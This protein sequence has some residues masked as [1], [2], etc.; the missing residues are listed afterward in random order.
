MPERIQLRRSKGWRK[1]E[2]AVIVARPSRWGN[3]FVVELYG[4]PVECVKAYRDHLHAAALGDNLRS[5]AAFHHI[6]ANL[7]MLRGH[8]LACWCPLNEPCHADVLLEVA[9]DCQTR[10]RS[11]PPWCAHEQVWEV[12]VYS[13]GLSM[14]QTLCVC[15]PCM[16]DLRSRHFQIRAEG[17]IGDGQS[18]TSLSGDA[19]QPAPDAIGAEM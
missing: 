2:G 11:T 5:S 8:D 10:I 19:P 6:A 7:S 3:P 14:W 4:T 9:N 16:E 18:P 1:P 12:E 15:G 17:T 13:P